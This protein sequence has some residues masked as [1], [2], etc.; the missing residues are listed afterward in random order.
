M[1][2]IFI[3]IICLISIIILKFALNIKLKDLRNLKNRR[4]DI[5]EK[6][7]DK[8]EK[9]EVICKEILT[10]LGNEKIEIK[11]DSESEASLYIVLTNKI[12][13][14]KFKQNYMKI[15]TIAHECIHSIQSKVMLWFNYIFSNIFNL[16]FMIV[17]ILTVFNKINNTYIQTIILTFLG[18]IQYIIRE[19][20]EYEAMLKAPILAKEYIDSKEI[21]EEDEK[22]ELNKEYNYITDIGTDFTNFMLISKNIIKIIIYQI[23][24]II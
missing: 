19:T 13:L 5:L 23:L 10:K 2:N 18:L 7:S 12:I 14:G 15:Q 21:F 3:I 24:V 17:S 9:E 11:L 4:N 16:Y 22:N 6:M 1:Q 8:F 20:L